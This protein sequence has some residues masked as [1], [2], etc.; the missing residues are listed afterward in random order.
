MYKS[1]RFEALRKEIQERKTRSLARDR[2]L[3][4]IKTADQEITEEETRENGR[5]KIIKSGGVTWY[6]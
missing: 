4:R 2:K 3:Q 1:K 6:E 5:K